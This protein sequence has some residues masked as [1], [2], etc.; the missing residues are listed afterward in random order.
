LTRY[1][2]IAKQ[3]TMEAVKVLVRKGHLTM[4]ELA[5]YVNTRTI[6]VQS[7]TAVLPPNPDNNS[8]PSN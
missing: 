2:E 3:H 8:S 6:T 5:E 1:E 7:M 4:E